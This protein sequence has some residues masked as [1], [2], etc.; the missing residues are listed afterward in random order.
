MLKSSLNTSVSWIFK[1]P[2]YYCIKVFGLAIGIMCL[3]LLIAYVRYIDSYDAHMDNRENTYR[4]VSQFVS[5]ET[6]QIIRPE[7][8]SNAWLEA[9]RKEYAGQYVNLVSSA[10]RTGALSREEFSF[11][12]EFYIAEPG[13]VDVFNL[14]FIAGS[15]A[16]ALEGPN[17][18]ILSE[19]AAVKYFP[20]EPQ[21]LGKPLLLNGAHTLEV[22]GIFQ[23]IPKNSNFPVNAVISYGS[24]DAVLGPNFLR[25]S[26]WVVY[27][28]LRMFM[29]FKD[30]PTAEFVASDLEDLPMRRAPEQNLD[31]IKRAQLTLG[32]QPV[33]AVY[34]DPLTGNF[35]GDDLTR[36]NTYIGIW[37]LGLLVI[38][39]ACVNHTSLTLAQLRLRIKE[40]GVRIALGATR[41]DLIAQFL[42][43]SFLVSIPA[44]LIALAFVIAFLP[45][46]SSIVSVPMETGEVI[47]AGLWGY[48]SLAIVTICLLASVAPVLFWKLSGVR[49]FLSKE[50]A[51]RNRGAIAFVQFAITTVCAL[52][53]LGVYLQIDFLKDVDVGLNPE[54]VVIMDTR[55]SEG[56]GTPIN[57]QA[58]KNEMLQIPGVAS[59]TS[60]SVMPPN[61]GNYTRWERRIDGG[62]SVD[63]VVSHIVVDPDFLSTFEIP[64]IAGRNFSAERSA[65]LLDQDSTDG[66]FGILLTENGARRFG[67]A[68]PAEAIGQ[69]FTAALD[70]ENAR[71]YVVIGVIKDFQFYP[72]EN[73]AYSIDILQGTTD[74]LRS[75]A[76]RLNEND[77]RITNQ[78]AAVWRKFVP[79]VPLNLTF[80]EEVI[81]RDIKAKTEGFVRAA[82]MAATVFLAT[83]LFGMYAQASYVCEE[84]TKSIAVR[85]ILGSSVLGILGNLLKRFLMP[86]VCSFTVAI[87][88]GFYGI[89]SFYESFQATVGY[90]V[91]WYACCLLVLVAVALAAV[92]PQSYRAVT[93]PPVT[94][95]RY[96]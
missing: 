90:P 52:V 3:V 44:L 42:F 24:V 63:V 45:V 19:S 56:Q 71:T 88:L 85:K 84:S 9:I 48:I 60:A 7:I 21:I 36:R 78:V 33:S 43:E 61:I 73:E 86:V 57:F 40:V 29:T 66:E 69:R 17:K 35:N 55:Y 96:E 83:A 10:K 51:Q 25:N 2:F 75:I 94:F 18:I 4:V 47:S 38:A 81:S 15:P 82:A 13:I 68:S 8:G 91:W 62:E 28:G 53:V 74:P 70:R 89:T 46:F 14:Q 54:N 64:L 93:R 6:G 23:D 50:K 1:Q 80:V 12:Q 76:L 32:L 49:A 22:T 27:D 34:L 26:N 39:S 5:V 30:K 72:S 77:E 95:L 65:E 58:M 79:G 87:P 41:L 31:A 16:S 37:L 67:I 59:Y 11:D 92:L 20:D